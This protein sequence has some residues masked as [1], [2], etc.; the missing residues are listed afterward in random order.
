MAELE[1]EHPDLPS[2]TWYLEGP[3]VR[4]VP[5]PQDLARQVQII[6]QWAD[7]LSIPVELCNGRAW[8]AL[9]RDGVLVRISTSV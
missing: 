1:R 9:T 5:V 7:T 4:A 8:F 6:E 3:G 2:L